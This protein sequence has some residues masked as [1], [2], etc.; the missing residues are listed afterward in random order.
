METILIL[1]YHNKLQG[2][3]QVSPVSVTVSSPLARLDLR[4]QGGT[5]KLTAGERVVPVVVGRVSEKF[6]IRSSLLLLFHFR[7][8]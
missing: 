3:V 6:L 8:D 2:R 5:D 4:S 7:Q 1:D